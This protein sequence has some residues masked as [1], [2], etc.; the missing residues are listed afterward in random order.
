[1]LSVLLLGPP[2]LLLDQQPLRV[3]RR[4]SRALVYY[5]AAH[6]GPLTR[7]HL[8]AFFW[9]DHERPAAQQILRTTLH[10]LRQALGPALVVE[11]DS[12]TLA[13][14]TH[15]D[16]RLFESSLGQVTTD[17]QHLTSTLALYR[18]DFL[19][20]F[21]LQDA[22]AFDDWVAAEQER[23]RRL[24]MRGLAVL[25]QLHQ[26]NH[27]LQAALDALNRALAFDPLQEDL[28]RAAL[29][30]Q[31]LSGDR[32]GAIRRY[33]H[34]RKLLDEEMGVPPMAETRVLYDAILGDALPTDSPPIAPSFPK[35][36]GPQVQIPKS[37]IQPSQSYAIPFT[38]RAVELQTLRDCALRETHPL[39]LIEGEPGIGK[40][41][42]AEEFMRESPTITLTGAAREL[43]QALPYQPVIEALR[44]LLARPD[45]P[46]IQAKLDLPTVWLSEV[47]RLLPEL[48]TGTFSSLPQAANE[49]RLWEGLNQFLLAL[50]RQRFVILFLDDLHWADSSTLALL[51][52]LAR[53]TA[54]TPILLLA[55]ARPPAPRTPLATLL[56]A[57]TREGRLERVSLGR[58]TPDDTVSLA[59]QLSPAYT[60]PLANWLTHTAE[61]NP[62][63][64]AE[65]VRYARDEE[66]LQANGTLNLA[67]L[68]ASPI[69]PQ[70]VY[71]LIQ[72]RLSHLSEPARRVLDAA[73]AAGRIFEFSVVAR[74][75]ALSE[76]AAL[77]AL[78]ELRA[79]HL[80]EPHGADADGLRY[81][82]DHSLTIE[83]AYR[84]VG[85]PRHRLLHRRVAE[86]ME[87][88]YGQRL[89]AVAGLLAWH[90]SEGN[91][92]ER[93]APYAFRAGQ[94]AAHLAAWKEAVA[95]YEQALAATFDADQRRSILMALGEAHLQAGES[96][97]AAETFRAA[98]ALA[99]ARGADVDAARLALAR[100]LLSQARYSEAIAL[101]QQVRETGQ[102][103]NA[104]DAELL[105]GTLISVEGS[106]L[107]GA[108]DHLKKAETLLLQAS[109]RPDLACLAQVK[110]EQGSVAAQQGNLPLAIA[111]YRETLAVADEAGA[112]I[113]LQWQILSRNNL[114]YH[115]N[116][117]GDSTALQYAREG[118][119]MAQEK[120]VLGLQPYLL[121]TLGEIALAQND[122]DMAEKYFTEGL[123]L[124]ERL[125]IP[126]R[127]AGL[128][129]NLA[130]VARQRGETA[131][132]VHR[133]STALAR[134]DA[135]G[136]SHLATQIRL[137]LV[138][139]LPLSEARTHLVQAR[140]IAES[141]GRRLLLDQV[142]HLEQQIPR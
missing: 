22:P 91:E 100:S 107:A 3:T 67:A 65:L 45:W 124:A 80:I 26:V 104:V 82:F 53:R 85:E 20:G 97:Q 8:L 74:A 115:L 28:Q 108:A 14:D 106:D 86:A 131:L 142:I 21:T 57:L 126:E 63:I 32:A 112:E 43:E 61:G 116:L 120:G 84:E 39:V 59:R 48:L 40:T 54:G 113:A 41:R 16:T 68:S 51:G 121:S 71:S 134:A 18:G 83:V 34:L 90:F 129:A 38:G 46:A 139:L 7:D 36:R 25:S 118:Q 30:L 29:R 119:S 114:A 87:S 94:L 117:M 50:T 127:L 15:I 73:V 77:D 99:S 62:Y 110:F 101:A 35:D 4:K 96:A 81:T 64:L 103:E 89:D 47:A 44:S 33:D 95:F 78:D 79:A 130:L 93:A 136:I 132:A 88:L 123:A 141:S 55:A 135:L 109:G 1:M 140:T 24:V 122:L 69:V 75:A 31:Y 2:Q 10:G 12:L 56:Q 105:W 92:P 9:P 11:E 42:L 138:P 52:Y 98:L 19:E 70:S 137:W 27:D 49:S 60:H 102:P 128:T 6:A 37:A 23:Y 66:L 17:L 13:P 133:L 125:S 76:N 72:S 58:L 111:F 5:L